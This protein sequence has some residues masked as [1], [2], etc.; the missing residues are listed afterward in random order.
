MLNS[1]AKIRSGPK[2]NFRVALLLAFHVL[3][4]IPL[5][6]FVGSSLLE[7]NG[8]T[9]WTWFSVPHNE[10]S[11]ARHCRLPAIVSQEIVNAV[12]S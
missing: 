12:R 6:M 9:Q 3:E 10:R 4:S 11:S 1:S 7:P 2:A 5:V 8:R